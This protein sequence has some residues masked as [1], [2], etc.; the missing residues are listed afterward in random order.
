[1]EVAPFSKKQFDMGQ[2]AQTLNQLE[3]INRI[4]ST[5]IHRI[6]AQL[7]PYLEYRQEAARESL[8]ASSPEANKLCIASMNHTENGIRDILSFTDNSN[9]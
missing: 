6:I 3:A 1:L 7:I 9:K 2:V 8:R 4:A 5:P